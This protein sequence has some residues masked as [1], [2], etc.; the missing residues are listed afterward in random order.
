MRTN[1][2]DNPIAT[3]RDLR[4]GL[5]YRIPYGVEQ[6]YTEELGTSWLDK[7]VTLQD[8]TY[9]SQ[10]YLPEY[11][12]EF[13]TFSDSKKRMY[14][15]NDTQLNVDTT[16]YTIYLNPVEDV[17]VLEDNSTSVRFTLFDGDFISSTKEI[18]WYKFKATES[19]HNCTVTWN[20]LRLYVSDTGTGN[21]TLLGQILIRQVST[22]LTV[23]RGM[24]H[25]V[26]LTVLSRASVDLTMPQYLDVIKDEEYEIVIS[27]YVTATPDLDPPNDSNNGNLGGSSGNVQIKPGIEVAFRAATLVFTTTTATITFGF[28][29]KCVPYNNLKS[30]TKAT[31]P[32]YVA[33][34]N[35]MVS[36]SDAGR[37]LFTYHYKTTSD[38]AWH[39]KQVLDKDWGSIPTSDRYATLQVPINPVDEDIS[40]DYLDLHLK[41]S[42]INKDVAYKVYYNDNVVQTSE[43]G[44]YTGTTIHYGSSDTTTRQYR[45]VVRQI[46][47]IHVR[48]DY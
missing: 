26:A 42:T 41:W 20:N 19:F 34:I 1:L 18:V 14:I 31:V 17:Q 47:Y 25:N 44:R 24:M 46:T 43:S 9:C 39:S 21:T 33:I 13:A 48:F 2:A 4:D 27:I 12:S 8:L 10:G 28:S 15:T 36:G 6:K 45:D 29:K 30:N 16:L 3:W 38:G 35:D 11:E 40:A 7:G 23:A 5:R 32:V 37:V 22:G